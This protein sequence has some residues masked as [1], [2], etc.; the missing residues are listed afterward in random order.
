MLMY[1]CF[2]FGILLAF[3]SI[4]FATVTNSD[5]STIT[6]EAISIPDISVEDI[7]FGDY[8]IGDSTPAPETAAVTV[9]NGASGRSVGLSLANTNIDLTDQDSGKTIGVALSISPAQITLD[10]SGGGSSTMTATL[11]GVPDTVGSYD[12]TATVIVEYN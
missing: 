3:N 5:T 11:Q 10:G 6:L 9:S 8:V 7:D 4:V 12:G 2:V 1:K